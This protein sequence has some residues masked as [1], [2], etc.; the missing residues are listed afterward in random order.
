MKPMD[1]KKAAFRRTKAHNKQLLEALRSVRR[2]NRRGWNGFIGG[3]KWELGKR[4]S[5]GYSITLPAEKK[6]NDGV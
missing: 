4:Y 1:P 5:G 2:W 3:R 6:P